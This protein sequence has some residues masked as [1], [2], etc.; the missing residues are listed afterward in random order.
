[1]PYLNYKNYEKTINT[2]WMQQCC[3][4]Q[5]TLLVRDV[6]GDLRVRGGG[7]VGVRLN[8]GERVL[9]CWALVK[10]AE[11]RFIGGNILMDLN[12]ECI[13]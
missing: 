4:R 10:R 13:E 6:P 11:H 5:E 7:M 3:R 12:L 2:T 9:D 8:L 1:M